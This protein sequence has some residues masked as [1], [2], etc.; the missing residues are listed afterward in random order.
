MTKYLLSFDKDDVKIV[1]VQ[2]N[3]SYQKM[4]K[5]HENEKAWSRVLRRNLS[6][7]INTLFEIATKHDKKKTKEKNI[8]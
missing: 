4:K 7:W 3:Y 6:F 2:L 5:K 1:G 8:Q